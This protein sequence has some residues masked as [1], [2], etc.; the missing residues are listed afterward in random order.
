M[1][2]IVYDLTEEANRC[3][4]RNVWA[5]GSEENIKIRSEPKET[6]KKLTVDLLVLHSDSI[7]VAAIL[8]GSKNF[9]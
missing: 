9:H 7:T 2:N 1:R 5:W 8:Y 3:K 4:S 6:E